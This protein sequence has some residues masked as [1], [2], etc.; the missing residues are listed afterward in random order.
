MNKK[1]EKGPKL[2]SQETSPSNSNKEAHL[3]PIRDFTENE[4]E[5]RAKDGSMKTGPALKRS[6]KSAKSDTGSV[7][8]LVRRKR[9]ASLQEE[10]WLQI[11]LKNSLLETSSL[12]DFS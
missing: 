5:R 4:N 10:R 8:S 12:Q 7:S 1:T 11:A 2:V 9:L 6:K 3:L